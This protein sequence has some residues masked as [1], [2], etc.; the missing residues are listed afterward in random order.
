MIDVLK[1][2]ETRSEVVLR[3]FVSD[4]GGIG[5]AKVQPTGRAGSKAG[6]HGKSLRVQVG[7]F[8]LS[9]VRA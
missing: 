1:A 9:F 8:K 5:M 6:Q 4:Q 3:Q 7:G 2:Q